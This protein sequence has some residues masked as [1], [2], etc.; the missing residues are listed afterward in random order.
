MSQFYE[1]PKTRSEFNIFAKEVLRLPNF[2]GE[3]WKKVMF[4]TV[5]AAGDTALKLSMF[6]YIYGATWSPQEY[7]D[8]NSYK[9]LVCAI[10]AITPTCALTV[11]FENARRA[12]YADK[13]WPIEMR[14]NYTSPTN[15]LMRIPFE[16]GA[17]N[18]FRGG[19]PIAVNQWLFW[20]TYLTL[21]TWDKNKFFYLWVYNDFNYEWCKLVNMGFSFAVASTIAYPA[22]YTREM[23]DLWPKE[24]G[25]HCT[26]N[27]NYRQCFKWMVEN[28]DLHS[29]NYLT[30]YVQW[31]RRYGI[32]Y[33]GGLWMADSLGMMSNVN[34]VFNGLE[35]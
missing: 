19:F 4:G 13:T 24:R 29:Y 28:M 22:Y 35:V 6:Q 32:L 5:T 16:E 27:N 17:W 20:V 8:W 11:P 34:E 14:R 33:L 3:M 15:A 10:F 7:V 26:F 31:V 12:Y 30:N 23:V 1:Y 21:Y 2:W 9:H 25:G 18:I